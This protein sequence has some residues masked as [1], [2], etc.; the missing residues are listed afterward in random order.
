MGVWLALSTKE[1]EKVWLVV[2]AM[3]ESGKAINKK[4]A[5]ALWQIERRQFF[6]VD[7]VFEMITLETNVVNRNKGGVAG[8]P[9]PAGM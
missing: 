7:L 6:H 2:W 1:I 5:E 3:E 9:T 4:K 8:T